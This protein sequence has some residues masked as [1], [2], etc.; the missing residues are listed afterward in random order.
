MTTSKSNIFR[1]I[2]IGLAVAS[3]M[4]VGC[5]TEPLDDSQEAP[6]RS[7]ESE[8]RAG[9]P[10]N[11]SGSLALDCAESNAWIV[12]N[13]DGYALGNTPNE[14]ILA[15]G[16]DCANWEDE[17]QGICD[18]MKNY[19]AGVWNF[20]RWAF[21]YESDGLLVCGCEC[22]GP[23]C[24]PADDHGNVGISYNDVGD[25]TEAVPY[26]IYN[27]FQLV[28]IAKENQALGKHYEQCADIDMN[29]LKMFGAPPRR[30]TIGSADTPFTG[31]YN[32][33]NFTIENFHYDANSPLLAGSSEDQVGLF[34]VIANAHLGNIKLENAAIASGIGSDV[35]TLVGRMDSSTVS[36]CQAS[37]KIDGWLTV[38][39]LVGRANA[40]SLISKSSAATHVHVRETS[41][42]AGGFVG[43]LFASTVEESSASGNVFGQGANEVGGFV[44]DTYENSS[45]RDCLATGDVFG[46]ESVGGFAGSFWRE[47]NVLNSAASGDVSGYSKVGGFVG[48]MTQV[49]LSN[50]SSS[51]D[52]NGHAA[53]GGLAGSVDQVS[54]VANCFS[55]GDVAGFYIVGG[56]SGTAVSSYF[57]HSR[58]TG[59]VSGT[60]NVGGFGGAITSSFVANAY[61]TGDVWGEASVGGF[62]GEFGNTN[63][64]VGYAAGEVIGVYQVGGF[65][66]HMSGGSA[67]SNVFALSQ[68][69][70]GQT[71]VGVL[72]GLNSSGSAVANSHYWSGVT[73]VNNNCNTNFATPQSQ[74]AHFYSKSN[75]PLDMWD[76]VNVWEE[77]P[78][79]TPVLK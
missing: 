51:G 20:D 37:G 13:H 78:G 29:I 57:T 23:G 25:G 40:N 30:F 56:F 11:A 7:E 60:Y 15:N 69:I 4:L 58:A 43:A 41:Y 48:V 16:E 34:G 22:A 62:A 71:S 28:S 46:N 35:G 38:G 74:Q 75:A 5:I 44:G 1:R 68:T 10:Q 70:K 24:N 17:G 33:N 52:V 73:C 45:I 2:S 18:A 19:G 31:S 36:N 14:L 8:F 55:S 72:I 21:V 54:F 50:C 3:I 42:R 12:N 76:F 27:A 47:T 32:G 26:R 64:S 59:D 63:I 61:A 65:A 39:G 67:M 49:S 6:P 77:V 79:S 9:D 66:G 53:V